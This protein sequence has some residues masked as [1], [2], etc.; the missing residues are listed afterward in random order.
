VQLRVAESARA[1]VETILAEFGH[2]EGLLLESLVALKALRFGPHLV[3]RQRR[4][5]L[6]ARLYARD[7]T[8]LVHDFHRRAW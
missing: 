1:E 8:V 6:L 4:L 2:L 7:S 3:A 5:L